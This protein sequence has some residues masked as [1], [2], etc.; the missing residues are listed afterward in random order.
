[1][2]ATVT[3]DHGCIEIMHTRNGWHWDWFG[4]RW[5]PGPAFASADEALTDGLEY[6]SLLRNERRNQEPAA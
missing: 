4:M 6:A 3:I 5:V 2:K 1:M